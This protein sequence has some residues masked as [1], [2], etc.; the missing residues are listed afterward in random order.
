MNTTQV[1]LPRPLTLS[2]VATGCGKDL[3]AVRSR[4]ARRRPDRWD[5]ANGHSPAALRELEFRQAWSEKR[6]TR[7]NRCIKKCDLRRSAIKDAPLGRSLARGRIEPSSRITNP[8]G[9]SCPVQRARDAHHAVSHPMNAEA[10]LDRYEA[11]SQALMCGTAADQQ[12]SSF[13][14][15]VCLS[16]AALFIAPTV[17]GEAGC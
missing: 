2:D 5:R 4:A 12:P 1:A 9:G 15:A 7:T 17:P 11:G 3:P 16:A 6:R 13:T 8:S 14:G 10:R